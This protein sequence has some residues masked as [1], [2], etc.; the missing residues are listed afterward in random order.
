MRYVGL[1]LYAEG[2]RDYYFLRPLLLRLC[3]ELCSLHGTEPVDFSEVEALDHPARDAEAPRS[4][5]IVSAA[6]LHRGSWQVLFIHSD[7]DNDSI[8]ARHE[9]VDPGIEAIRAAFAAEGRAVGVVPVR[10][11]ESWTLQDG[12]AL[13]TVFGTTLSDERMGLPRSVQAVEAAADPKAMLDQAFHATGPKGH[14]ARSGTSPH[15]NALGEQVS[16]ER[17]RQLPSFAA[18]AHELE[19]TLRALRVIA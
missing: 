15:L 5:R 19:D 12:E 7:G 2:P 6:E 10:E 17:L 4:Q 18:L 11:T 1:A 14:R 13:R 3:T 16:L 9:R 8:A